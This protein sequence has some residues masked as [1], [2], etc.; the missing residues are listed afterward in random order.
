MGPKEYPPVYSASEQALATKKIEF[1]YDTKRAPLSFG[2][3]SG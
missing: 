1:N 3:Q 2:I